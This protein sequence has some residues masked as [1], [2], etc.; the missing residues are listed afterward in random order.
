[1]DDLTHS[2][3]EEPGFFSSANLTAIVGLPRVSRLIVSS[4]DLSFASR[5][6]FADL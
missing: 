1:M 2:A 4:S 3:F 5:R 6:L